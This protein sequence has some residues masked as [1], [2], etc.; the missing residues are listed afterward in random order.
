MNDSM[1]AR[2]TILS[3]FL[4]SGKTTWLAHQLRAGPLAGT[5]VLVN[6]AAELPVDDRL[7]PAPRV[8]AGGCACCTRLGALGVT[9]GEMLDEGARHIVLETSGLAEPGRIVEALRND[10][11][12]SG[13][14]VVG[15]TVVTLDTATA[16]DL[17]RSE[18][19]ARSQVEAADAIVLTKLASAAPDDAARLV[20]S[21]RAFAPRAHLFAA[22]RGVEVDVPSADDAMPEPLGDCNLHG[23]G[24]AVVAV[25]LDLGEAPDLA[26]VV[27]WLSAL[28]HARGDTILRVKGVVGDTGRRVLIQAAGRSVELSDADP[29][30]RGSA[31]GLV[32]IGRGFEPEA[33]AGSL[34]GF[35]ITAR[36]T[37]RS[38][39]T[40][41]R[42][43]NG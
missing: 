35:G 38:A 8:L 9:L 39:A 42:P 1:P 3:G 2:L 28:L 34:R 22:E 37:V 14:L 27:L 19:L 5:D 24:G 23:D 36:M 15:E 17:L 29:D 7:L 10:G 25:A 18:P 41:H 31:D 43:P 11:D 20:A 13:R 40:G 32:V 6:E 30:D 21:L 33:L 12:L 26:A 16:R 4:G